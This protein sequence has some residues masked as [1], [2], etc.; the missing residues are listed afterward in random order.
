MR[1]LSLDD[2]RARDPS[3]VGGKAAPLAALAGRGIPVPP[4]FVVPADVLARHLAALGVD[5]AADPV[6]AAAAVHAAALPKG[7]GRAL[8]REAARLG[9]R[10]AVRSSATGEDGSDAS[11]A[12]QYETVLGVAPGPALHDAVRTCWAS[13]FA[14]RARAYRG[15]DGGVPHMAVLVQQLVDPVCAGVLFTI[16]PASGSWR[17]MTVEAAWGLGEAVVSGRVVP[18]HYRVRRPRRIPGPAQR[19][20]AR[21]RLRVVEDAVRSQETALH[22]GPNGV[23]ERLVPPERVDAPKLLHAEV[24]K[25]CRLGLRIEAM[26]GAPQDIEWVRDPA[27]RLLVVQAR[28]ITTAR[29]VRRS[30]PVVW[31]R[32]FVGERWTE[33][34]T[35][36]GWSLMRDLLEWFIAYPGTSRRFLGGAEPLQLQRFAP[37]INVTVFRHLAF[38]PPGAPPPRF[39]VE[40]LPPDEEA[41][42]LRTRGK[43]PDVRVYRS[44]LAETFEERRWRRFRWNP[45]RNWAHWEAFEGRLD[46][47]LAALPAVADRAGARARDGVCRALA[48]EYLSIH[49]CSLLFANIWYQLAE[50]ALAAEGREADVPLLLRPPRPTW[51]TRANHALWRLGRGEI[52]LDDVLAEFGHR[53]PS[54]WELFSDRWREAPERVRVLAEG[55]ATGEDPGARVGA[56]AADA[57]ARLAALDRPTRALVV[58]ARR[59]LQLREDQRFHFDRI[60]W[61][62]KEAWLWLEADTGLALRFLEAAEVTALLDG[63]LSRA[64]AEALVA[65]RG[66][67]WTAEVARRARGDEPPVFLVGE[68]AADTSAGGPRLTGQGISAGVTTATVRVIR[69]LDE[70]ARLREGEVLVARATDP[71]WTPLFGRAGAL[72]LELGGMLS[73]GAVVAREYGLPAVVNVVGATTRLVD[74]QTVTVDGGRGVVFVH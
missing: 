73:H 15:G 45:V 28:P 63:H 66:A 54:S 26:Q 17:E 65:R 20:V 5:A 46:A 67:A 48:R 10:L 32:R 42:W 4:G 19:L 29:D 70:G 68:A 36:L 55:V 43:L 24:L 44:I 35:P 22:G 30:G 33:P 27:G 13:A 8:D 38:K 1:I 2:P 53:A 57:D 47:A 14:A 52:E 49:V 34:A 23:E 18:D 71:G 39:M 64:D 12:G 31:T 61:R 25:L 16:N 50:G 11:F 21:M 58:M 37:Y 62:W 69:S 7:L 74:G 41:R 51:T 56:G 9:P 3:R 59:Y 6:A 72:V 60:L 40:L